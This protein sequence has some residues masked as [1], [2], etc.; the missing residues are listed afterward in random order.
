MSMPKE[1][2]DEKDFY[3]MTEEEQHKW[4]ARYL[5]RLDEADDVE[6]SQADNDLV[7]YFVKKI[8]EGKM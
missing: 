7:D 5:K 6:L 1:R 2:V 4:L 8:K 3:E